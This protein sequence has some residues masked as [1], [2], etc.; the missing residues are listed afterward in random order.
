MLFLILH[1]RYSTHTNN[2]SCAT[3]LQFMCILQVPG[4]LLLLRHTEDCSHLW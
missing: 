4:Q 3:E 1:C 2:S